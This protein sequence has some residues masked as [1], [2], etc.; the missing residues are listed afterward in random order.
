MVAGVFRSAL[1]AT[2]VALVLA[3]P[4]LAA[5]SRSNYL[6]GR[7]FECWQTF[8]S[9][10]PTGMLSGFNRA[11]RGKVAF[12][13][14]YVPSYLRAGKQGSFVPT[15]TGV[16]FTSGPFFQPDKGWRLLGDVHPRGV[17]MPHD[18]RRGTR[19]QLVLRSAPGKGKV[20]RD[21]PP[22]RTGRNF[23][24]TPWYCNDVS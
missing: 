6:S 3:P 21:A 22:R 2:A 14:D 16:R 5:D 7:T 19:Y 24:I 23:I 12:A 11:Q 13:T 15:A 1:A 9:Y 10:G 17:T 20:S 18:K 8:A 4:A